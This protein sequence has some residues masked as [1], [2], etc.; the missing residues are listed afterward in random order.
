MHAKTKP[1][2]AAHN[3]AIELPELDPPL[4]SREVICPITGLPVVA[5]KPGQRGLSVEEIKKL[6]E[7]FP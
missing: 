7:D 5:A 2:D 3:G 1:I 4:T 6:L